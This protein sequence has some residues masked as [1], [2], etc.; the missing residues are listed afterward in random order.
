MKITELI[1]E[2]V[3]Y[4]DVKRLNKAVRQLAAD[5]DLSMDVPPG[6]PRIN[7]DEVWF[8][9]R[10]YPK[11]GAAAFNKDAFRLPTETLYNAFIKELAQLLQAELDAGKTVKLGRGTMTS[12]FVTLKPGDDIIAAIKERTGSE[13][14]YIPSAR[15]F[16]QQTFPALSWSV[17]LPKSERGVFSLSLTVFHDETLTKKNRYIK[18]QME[19]YV[20]KSDI[21]FHVFASPIKIKKIERRFNFFKEKISQVSSPLKPKRSDLTQGEKRNLLDDFAH[22]VVDLAVS[23]GVKLSSQKPILKANDSFLW[24]PHL[25]FSSKKYSEKSVEIT[26]DELEELMK[27]FM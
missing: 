27:G 6:I 25:T 18:G 3:A 21:R 10:F 23:K 9:A 17:S 20:A 16:Q 11:G 24:R 12:N 26:I 19:E 7:R 5:L 1:T 13:E 4:D 22:K 8:A 14:I 15:G 2:A